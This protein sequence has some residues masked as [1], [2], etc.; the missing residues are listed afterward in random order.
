[1]VAFL[2]GAW[3]WMPHPTEGWLPVQLLSQ[4]P[5]TVTARSSLDEHFTF[6]AA[7]LPSLTSCHPASLASSAT[8][9]NLTDLEELSE[10]SILHTLRS[11]YANNSIYTA[12]STIL[13][14]IN[15]Y[16]TLPIYGP[17][18][19]RHY[20]TAH[21]SH[22]S[23]SPHVYSLAHT[24]YSQLLTTQQ[25]QSIVIAG[26]SG[27]GKTEST[28]LVLQYMAELSGAGDDIE[29]QLLECNPIVEAF[30]N[31]KT[32]KNNNSSRFGKWIEIWFNDKYK[33]CGSRI[34]QY[35]LERSRVVLQSEGESNFHI[36]YALINGATADEKANYHLDGGV[37][38]FTIL[39]PVSQ[40]E[41]PL[42]DVRKAMKT[43]HFD[44]RQIDC[45]FRVLA[46]ILHLGNLTFT[47]TATPKEPVAI[48]NKPTLSIVAGL[49]SM[50]CDK[51]CKSLLTRR[52]LVGGEVITQFHSVEQ[53]VEMCQSMCK[54]WYD[55]L[56][57]Y[58][59][60]HINTTLSNG[61]GGSGTGNGSHSSTRWIGVL[62]IFGF[63][64]FPIN[65]WE[66]LC[67]NYTNEK[68]QQHFINV[69]LSLDQIEYKKEN[70]QVTTVDFVDNQQ[71]LELIEQK[72]SGIFDMIS[73]EIKLPKGNDANLLTRMHQAYDGKQG[74]AKGGKHY[75]KPKTNAP[76][77]TIKH[78]AGD[79]VYQVDKFM[80]KNKGDVLSED[81]YEAMDSCS[82]P[83]I[84]RLLY[85]NKKEM[86]VTTAAAS[87]TP[88]APA[89]K[90][91]VPTQPAA[92]LRGTSRNQAPTAGSIFRTQLTDLMATLNSTNPH[93][94]K[95]LKPNAEKVADM[96]D[97]VFVGRQLA[98]LG[99]REV[100][101]VRKAGYPV[102]VKRDEW[103]RRYRLLREGQVSGEAQKRGDD[104]EKAEVTKLMTAIEA[105]TGS[106][107][108]GTS[109][110]LM[111]QQVQGLLEEKREK[112]VSRLIVGLQSRYRCRLLRRKYQLIKQ[113]NR[114]LLA[115]L[116]SPAASLATLPLDELD[117]LISRAIDLDLPTPLLAKAKQYRN[118][119]A[120]V[121]TTVRALA[122]SVRSKDRQVIEQ[123]LNQ[124]RSIALAD[125]VELREAQDWVVRYDVYVKEAEGALVTRD[126]A[127][128]IRC[129]ETA[130]ALGLDGPLEKQLRDAERLCR[131]QT[132]LTQQLAALVQAS[133][134]VALEQLSQLL[135][136]AEAMNLQSAV[137]EQARKKRDKLREEGERREKE[138][139]DKLSSKGQKIE[140]WKSKLSALLANR[141]L[142]R[143]SALLAS[144]AVE[145]AEVQQ[146]VRGSSIHGECV[147]W[148]QQ[149]DELLASCTAALQAHDEPAM[150]AAMDKATQ[151]GLDRHPSI[152]VLRAALA[153]LSQAAELRHLLL[154]GIESRQFDILQTVISRAEARHA[155]KGTAVRDDALLWKAKTLM[156]DIL[157]EKQLVEQDE[158]TG[159]DDKEVRAMLH[160][161]QTLQNTE[162]E[163]EQ[164][165]QQQED[166]KES[167]G[168]SSLLRSHKPFSSHAFMSS[169]L[170]IHLCPLL[171]SPDDFVKG[172]WMGKDKLKKSMLTH[173][174]EAIPRSLTKLDTH[175]ASG[176]AS[177]SASSH[178]AV[179]H[180][181][182]N[183][184]EHG[185]AVGLNEQALSAFKNIQGWMG[186]RMY[187]FPDSL[188]FDVLS[189]GVAEAGM[190][191]E[192]YAQCI[193]QLRD[194]P[195]LESVVRGWQLIGL[196]SECFLPSA[197]FLPYLYHFLLTTTHRADP[198]L[199]GYISYTLH[200]LHHG[201]P[202]LAA[203][204]LTHISSFRDRL[205][206]TLI[207]PL[208]FPDGS[209]VDVEVSPTLSANAI[210][211]KVLRWTNTLSDHSLAIYMCGPGTA[212]QAIGGDEC[213]LDYPASQCQDGSMYFVLK[214]R[215]FL[216][217]QLDSSRLLQSI[218]YHQCVIDCCHGVYDLQRAELVQVLA[219]HRQLV[220]A[221][222]FEP[223]GRDTPNYHNLQSVKPLVFS[224]WDPAAIQ[225][226]EQDVT[227]L[228]HQQSGGTT[229][230]RP[231]PQ[232]T[233][234]LLYK[235]K[236]FSA[237]LFLVTQDER[238]E[239]PSV[240][241]LAINTY[242]LC[243]VHETNKAVISAFRY[244]HI[245]GWASNSVRFCLRVL[246]SR[247]K[248]VQLNFKTQH[249]KRIVRCVQE[250]VEHI[251]MQ[252]RRDKEREKE[253]EREREREKERE[254]G[255]SQLHMTKGERE[256]QKEQEGDEGGDVH[257]LKTETIIHVL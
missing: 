116:A 81:V 47:A 75:V 109:K 103:L 224:Y 49:L 159:K 27:A 147:A 38:H 141:Q 121:Q 133:Q 234:D 214:K 37:A 157:S 203:P 222:Y 184:S 62:D 175:T 91:S 182:E 102:R 192:I 17:S 152:D 161:Q 178:A 135:Q 204:S 88:A 11:R 120:T 3:V 225:Q 254:R 239:L 212:C 215:M 221:H 101:E 98:Y 139:A 188:A 211:G 252:Q 226:F 240:L 134:P 163:A 100:V 150:Q 151:L 198:L 249:G 107:V 171:R 220:D 173:S 119:V 250:Y 200:T 34:S 229:A 29:Q 95:C 208:H 132:E 257:G 35:L 97:G 162:Q 33:I 244:A 126:A 104:E 218:V 238:P 248:T 67:I 242:G 228:I 111:K 231:H 25:P 43:L 113:C 32:I 130:A 255:S 187:S 199:L 105:P 207:L 125:C 122:A 232:S 137:V 256:E 123:A 190:R 202:T 251:M 144:L 166:S 28:K 31:A 18:A 71:C 219:T 185:E 9:D 24:A 205:M 210:I 117:A 61:H 65:Y 136:Q 112:K 194:N 21:S 69:C 87:A 233:F 170:S 131:Q 253:R 7:S 196:L 99:V 1:M 85:A 82:E 143:L 193:K 230:V 114:Q 2:E 52:L 183:A 60:E 53:C 236:E 23:P 72:R 124:A 180:D 227:A 5:T 6:P 15:P 4:T 83:F 153:D 149:S 195:K 94:L 140:E 8:V 129:V 44:E 245:T 93:F 86:S 76:Q 30:G 108:N 241:L 80:E 154:T 90:I 142:D 70:V 237:Q 209:S 179:G 89:R 197:G 213:L 57:C 223:I 26:E 169:S 165:R 181:E 158:A 40:E 79:V 51:L 115:M 46:A 146:R 20:R 64:N 206:H 10:G 63:E 217:S 155:A 78:Y 243:L 191:D 176:A 138:E 12:I 39:R 167:S 246:V 54:T 172:R 55:S 73:E 66:Q 160:Q 174:K 92:N 164:R 13:L 127:V 84:S 16:K 110:V 145:D 247:G 177:P 168:S 19:I 77:F 128:L 45:I 96:F 48:A 22:Q 50:D 59:I 118:K 235:R 148:Q 186:D 216:S 42:S 189:M 41:I 58:M 56:F 156:A 36:F 68:L 74:E 14:S 106:W 201:E